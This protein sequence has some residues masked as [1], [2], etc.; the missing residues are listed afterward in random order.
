MIVQLSDLHVGAGESPQPLEDARDAV[1]AILALR[2]RPDAVLVTGDLAEHGSPSEY[3]AVRRLLA[4]LPMP[5]HVVAGNHDARPALRAAFPAPGGADAPY[6]WTA[7]CGALRLVG[8]DTTRP[9]RDDGR[10]APGELAW[11]REQLALDRDAPTVVAMH[12][13]P[14]ATGMPA[15]DRYAL[16]AGDRAA[17]EDLLR[18]FPHVQRVATGHVHMAVCGRIAGA[19]ATTCPSTWRERPRLEIGADEWETVR[20]P[21]GMLI[22]VLVAG[23]LVSHVQPLPSRDG[24]RP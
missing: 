3:A 17:L 13:P 12:H 2:P 22:H 16:A 4:N 14:L 20:Q 15:L 10:L 21:A 8:C 18:G 9:G 7:R 23:E 1:D 5:V 11:L 19:V 24:E 6:R